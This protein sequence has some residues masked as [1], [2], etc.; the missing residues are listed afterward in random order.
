MRTLF[1]RIGIPLFIL[2]IA[3]VYFSPIHNY[4]WAPVVI[5]VLLLI[6]YY[7]SVQT[8]HAIL[9]NF[10]VL[11][12]LR[13]FFEM[14]S[15]EMQQYFIERN[16]DGKPFSRAERSIVYQRAKNLDSSTPFGTQLELNNEG[17]EGLK[18]SIY[19]SKIK[20]ELPRVMVGGPACSQPYNASIYNIS[21]MS[22]G[23]LSRAAVLALNG[24][25]KKGNFF[26]NTGE[27][28]L[29]PHHLERGGDICWQIGTGYF[30]CRTIDG[31]FSPENF[32]AKATL[33]QVKMIEIKISQGAKPG[34]G[35]VL[36]ASKNSVEVSQIRGVEPH[37]MVL[38]PP[39]H[40]AFSNPKEL[41]DF[42]E[43]LRMLS[44]GK[45][46]GF[47]LC[48]GNTQ[49]FRD[50]CAEMQR[51][52]SFPDFITVDGAEG[53]TGAAP[54]EFTNA[55]GMPLEPAMIFVN[56]CLKDY[57]VREHIKLIASGKI[58]SAIHIIK[59]IA[60]GADMCNSA[61]GFMFSLGCIQALRCHNNQCPTGVATQDKM[62][63]KGLDVTDKTERVYQFHKNTL[64][65]VN[66]LLA[67]TGKSD[68]KDIDR[69]MFM[70][71]DELIKLQND[72]YGDVFT[73]YKF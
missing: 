34:H 49:E 31:K 70:R 60:L 23:S 47:K 56:Q 48:I 46:V 36:P 7:N 9:R 54:L 65:A 51:R 10:P 15:P 12:Y 67:A 3:W 16:T 38:S 66:E 33:P 41:I 4:M 44:G 24:G 1:F 32:Q 52:Q 63:I 2:S 26:H 14:I 58:I 8:K 18:H 45:P 42:I 72:Y 43:Q 6:G 22:F 35:G 55:V 37:T 40:S 29:S 69:N 64:H 5:G 17:Y 25:A 57:G 39:G 68:F 19:P 73:D 11:G 13:Y 62:L 20:E 27:G 21:A 59:S 50:I 53:G 30:G 61:R 28:G 71:G